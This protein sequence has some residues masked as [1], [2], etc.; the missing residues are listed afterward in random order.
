MNQSIANRRSD[1][2]VLYNQLVQCSDCSRIA[3]NHGDLPATGNTF[4]LA[5][6]AGLGIGHRLVCGHLAHVS[7]A[8]TMR[9]P[10]GKLLCDRLAALFGGDSDGEQALF[11][12]DTD[13]IAG[14]FTKAGGEGAALSKYLV[15][16]LLQSG[17]IPPMDESYITSNWSST[18]I[19]Q[20]AV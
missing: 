16:G 1:A 19:L 20:V 15:H 12:C 4:S 2:A 3:Q 5:F 17:P 7:N 8:F 9:L 13:Q 10:A 18:T 11:H 14:L 6:G